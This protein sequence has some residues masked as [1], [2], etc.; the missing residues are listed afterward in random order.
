MHRE[1]GR[2]RRQST[3]GALSFCP[4]APPKVTSVSALRAARSGADAPLGYLRRAPAK[5]IK[6]E[7][8]VSTDEFPVPSKKFPVLAKKSL[9]FWPQGIW[10][11]A[12]D[13]SD[14]LDRKNASK[15]RIRKNSLLNSLFSG[16]L[17]IRFLE[18]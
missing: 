13:L 5:P 9:F 16:N 1:L 8:P 17:R 14:R 4:N 10:V 2:P 3:P 12:F 7:F 11:Q 18:T 6:Q 15:V